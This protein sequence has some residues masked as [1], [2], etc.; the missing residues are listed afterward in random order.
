MNRFERLVAR[1][2]ATVAQVLGKADDQVIHRQ[3]QSLLV[4]FEVGVLHRVQHQAIDLPVVPA[5]NRHV[6]LPSA[7]SG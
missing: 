4:L 3:Q 5:G 6:A 1:Q 2:R 7:A